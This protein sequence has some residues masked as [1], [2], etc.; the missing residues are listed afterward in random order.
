MALL[1]K[2]GVSQAAQY[3]HFECAPVGNIHP[4][5][6]ASVSS[7]VQMRWGLAALGMLTVLILREKV[8]EPTASEEP[9]DTCYTGLLP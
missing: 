5:W 9:A 6:R 2:Y 8:A 4:C 3:R 7:R 1:Y